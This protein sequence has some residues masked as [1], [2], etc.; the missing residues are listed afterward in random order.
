MTMKRVVYEVLRLDDEGNPLNLV[1][2]FNEGG[3]VAQIADSAWESSAFL[4]ATRCAEQQAEKHP[5]WSFV[6]EKIVRTRPRTFAIAIP[7]RA[8]GGR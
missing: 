2:S 3:A 6:V 4:A 8:A 1:R 7:R 5:G